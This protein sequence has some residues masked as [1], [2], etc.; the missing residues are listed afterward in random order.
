MKKSIYLFIAIVLFAI[1]LVVNAAT[2]D[3]TITGSGEL[4]KAQ[5]EAQMSA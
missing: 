1:P 5:F 2:Y 3:I 4:T